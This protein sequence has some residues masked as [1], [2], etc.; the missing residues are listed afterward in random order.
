LEL[1]SARRS[2]RITRR[3]TAVAEIL[4]RERAGD[5][6]PFDAL[7]QL[8]RKVA[9]RITELAPLQAEFWLYAVRNPD[10]MGVMASKLGEQVDALE[11]LVVKVLDA[12]A[13]RPKLRR[14]R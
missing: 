1:L 3:V 10:A 7:G 11:P 14:G 5:E 4:D 9:D 2:Q 12:P 8:F 6:D 13:V